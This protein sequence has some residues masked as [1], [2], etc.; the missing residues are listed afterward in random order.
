MHSDYI[1][2]YP[3]ILTLLILLLTFVLMSAQSRYCFPLK[4][5]AL[6]ISTTWQLCR[7]LLPSSG[8]IEAT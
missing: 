8:W 1:L 4:M 3:R 5:D 7:A 2:F 6:S